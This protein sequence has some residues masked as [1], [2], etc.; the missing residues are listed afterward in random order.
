MA[1]GS[2]AAAPH[3]RA[4]KPNAD[5]KPKYVN[6]IAADQVLESSAFKKWKETAKP[7]DVYHYKTGTIQVTPMSDEMNKIKEAN[8]NTNTNA[9]NADDNSPAI[10]RR[11]FG[12]FCIPPKA[13][14]Y[15]LI[16]TNVDHAGV[17]WGSWGK[18]GGCQTCDNGN[19]NICTLG[20]DW[21]YKSQM[22]IHGQ[23]F[24][25]YDGAIYSALGSINKDD[26]FNRGYT[27]AK[28]VDRTQRHT[29]DGNPGEPVSLWGQ[30]VN[31]WSDIA[32]RFLFNCPS[33]DGSYDGYGP[34]LFSHIDWPVNVAHDGSDVVS[35]GCSRGEKAEC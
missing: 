8:A 1:A 20:W 15:G 11:Q 21:T 4:D 35:L 33:D 16:Q 27:W 10:E 26:D 34:W 19:G 28:E 22:V 9:T 18:L 29:C 25:D 14:H 3:R 7:G 23:F 24:P 12:G 31:G 2:V 6:R 32:Q 13:R 30:T 5:D 17:W